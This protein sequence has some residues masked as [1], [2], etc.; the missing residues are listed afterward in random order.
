MASGS[1]NRVIHPLTVEILGSERSASFDVGSSFHLGFL[2]GYYRDGNPS[3][4]TFSGYCIIYWYNNTVY[5]DAKTEF[6][7]LNGVSL[8]NG[9]L[10][11][12]TNYGYMTLTFLPL[13]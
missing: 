8:S 13:Y 3:V 12:N 1:T 7:A 10:T 6:S 11:V 2:I 9:V 5:V 4:N